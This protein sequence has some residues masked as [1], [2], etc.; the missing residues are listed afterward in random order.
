VENFETIN[1]KVV[2]Y[3]RAA[4]SF[5]ADFS[6][7]NLQARAEWVDLFKLLKENNYQL[8]ILTLTKVSFR[9]GRERDFPQKSRRRG[10]SSY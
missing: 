1:S 9:K 6:V 7:E 3:K 10:S 4:I 5:P 8:G 2:S